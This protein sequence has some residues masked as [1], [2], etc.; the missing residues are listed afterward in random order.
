MNLRAVACRFYADFI[1]PCRLKEFERMLID[2]RAAGYSIWPV[3]SYWRMSQAGMIPA[4][5]RHMVL[6]HDIDTDPATAARMWEIERRIGVKSRAPCWKLPRGN[7]CWKPFVSACPSMD[8]RLPF[9][10]FLPKGRGAK[11]GW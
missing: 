2:I 6:R 11:G 8:S 5:G 10:S 3:E 4:G 7:A 9:L 1:M